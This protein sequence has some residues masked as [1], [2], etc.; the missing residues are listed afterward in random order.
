MVCK[1]AIVMKKVLCVLLICM[2]CAPALAETVQDQALMFIREAGIAADSVARF[3]DE[4]IVNLPSG[5][6]AELYSYGDFDPL[7]FSWRFSGAADEEVALYLDHA[8]LQLDKLEQKIPG[9]SESRARNY[10]VMV[11]N[12]LLYLENVGQ[13]GLRI[14]L[15]QLAAHDDSGLNSLRARLASRLLGSLDVTPVDPAEGL[16][17][18]DA[19]TISVQDDLPMPDASVYVDDPFLAEV[20]QLLIAHEEE[21]RSWYT[22]GD[23][24][25]PEKTATFVLLSEAAARQE[26]D[27]AV[28]LCHMISEK[29]ALYDGARMKMLSGGWYPVR[30]EL[31]KTAEG[32]TLARLIEPED[33]T[34]YW[35]SILAFCDGDEA[36]ARSLTAANTP[37]LHAAHDAALKNWLASIGYPDVTIE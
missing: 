9:A 2:L 13:Q 31:A 8:L 20:T 5:G 4:I 10:A 27:R 37:E 26:G 36:Q 34:Y 29:I 23:D 6:T 32:W 28:V 15:E 35:S 33:G 18:Y 25:E 24:V 21:R 17:W 19:L 7:D 14:L 3:G 11:S 12:S 30:V 22:W 1:E 16:A